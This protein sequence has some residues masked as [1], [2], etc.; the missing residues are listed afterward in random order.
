MNNLLCACSNGDLQNIKRI[1]ADPLLRRS[2]NSRRDNH[3]WTGLHHA[4]K[5]G[6]FDC[7][8]AMLNS[9]HVPVYAKTFEGM[10]A[11]HL[12]CDL[13]GT[14]PDVVRLL[15]E[16]YPDLIESVNNERVCAL[17]LA[18]DRNR[19]D[20]A[21]M[22]IEIGNANVNS[23]DLDGEYALF[24]AIRRQN[25]SLI[26]YLLHSTNSHVSEVNANNIDPLTLD[27]HLFRIQPRTRLHFECLQK[28]A[29]AYYKE[30]KSVNILINQIFTCIGFR[31]SEM[32]NF[33]L[34]EFYVKSIN[35]PGYANDLRIICESDSLTDCFKLCL[36]ASLH[37]TVNPIEN[38]PDPIFCQSYRNWINQTCNNAIFLLFTV[39]ANDMNTYH[40]IANYWWRIYSDVGTMDSRNSD[41]VDVL[42]C[43]FKLKLPHYFLGD[44]MCNAEHVYTTN[45]CL[46]FILA[47]SR[48]PANLAINI[49]LLFSKYIVDCIDNNYYLNFNRR[50]FA[51][52]LVFVT[53][54]YPYG[55][56]CHIESDR[57]DCNEAFEG[58]DDICKDIKK[59]LTLMETIKDE[60]RK[61]HTL[62][63]I[64]RTKIREII[65][66][67]EN[68]H[69]KDL[70]S[71][72][73]PLTL[74]AKLTYNTIFDLD[75]SL[76]ENM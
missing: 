7:V 12:A 18:I 44:M 22:L 30:S 6:D 45:D 70:W 13:P 48:E 26:E 55:F 59:Y 39:I 47:M 74:K 52:L 66:S 68:P 25:Y 1:L 5:K 38:S 56:L 9:P 69:G 42:T 10:T 4:I 57:H 15:V 40:R 67:R 65:F 62:F 21:K 28:L 54:I 33:F 60:P 37:D 20:L 14:S 58:T 35:N 24:Y 72:P 43:N 73:L 61:P 49:E 71:L 19:S 75:Q 34:Y 36:V 31:D 76:L 3:N 32:C 63:N 51:F 17:H 41:A 2:E 11:L 27:L 29:F 46:H 53:E 50:L 23:V 16:K 64:T 8:R